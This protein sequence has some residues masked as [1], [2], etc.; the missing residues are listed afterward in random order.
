MINVLFIFFLFKL[1]RYLCL[2]SN[3]ILPEM[4]TFYVAFVSVTN[5]L[6]SERQVLMSDVGLKI[7]MIYNKL[8]FYKDGVTNDKNNGK[9]QYL[10]L[11]GRFFVV[12]IPNW[13]KVILCNNFVFQIFAWNIMWVID[14]CFK[15]SYYQFMMTELQENV[16]EVGLRS[17]ISLNVVKQLKLMKMS[18]DLHFSFAK[19]SS[20]FS[21]SLL[22]WNFIT[23]TNVNT[24]CI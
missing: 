15:Y 4:C 7:H 18:E 14:Y 12:V 8:V 6:G 10:C 9:R 21:G 16:F 22:F 3:W 11:K 1:A 24:Y 5:K 2:L 19:L 23:F 13:S 20:L 17:D